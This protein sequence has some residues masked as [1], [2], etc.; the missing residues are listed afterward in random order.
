MQSYDVYV[1]LISAQATPNLVPIL[2]MNPRPK[3]VL[4]MVTEKMA[5]QADCFQE[6]LKTQGIHNVHQ[7]AL[8]DSYDLDS[9]KNQT[10]DLLEQQDLLDQWDKVAVNITGGTKLMSLATYLVFEGLGGKC[11]YFTE[12]NQWID[13]NGGASE[14]VV[15]K[16]FSIESLLIAQGFRI[17]HNSK[18]N[19]TKPLN[20]P[21]LTEEMVR[22][23]KYSQAISDL[24]YE[25]SQA[26]SA[27]QLVYSSDKF[28][29]YGPLANLLDLF[30]QHGVLSQKG[31]TIT[32]AS[33][34]ELKFA[35]GGWFEEHIYSVVKSLPGIQDL[36]MG[37]QIDNSSTKQTEGSNELD[38]VFTHNNHLHVIECKT[39]NYQSAFN[40][41]EDKKELDRLVALKQSGGSA[42]RAL[43]A[44]F[45]QL[46]SD[47]RARAEDKNIKIIEQNDLDGLKA[48]LKKWLGV[49]ELETEAAS[50]A[51]VNEA[52]S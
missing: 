38:V 47:V 9:I 12:Q 4:L 49:Q 41:G 22:F 7:I 43:F 30:A 21:E 23:K 14:T 11:F 51:D 48:H 44:S 8:S 20:K 25:L 26:K 39:V 18:Y 34:D 32:F 16:K 24:N 1:C 29:G 52:A 13:L 17:V 42:T 31:N 33:E 50:S 19:T 10:M 36:R 40:K 6:V 2:S 37:V 3:T 5:K 45:K 15:L 35:K 27:S 28:T 46:S